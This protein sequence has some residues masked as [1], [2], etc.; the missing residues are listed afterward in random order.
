MAK[1]SKEIRKA[2]RA[3]EEA[4][5]ASAQARGA[6]RSHSIGIR[7]LDHIIEKGIY[8]I[9]L[10]SPLAF[11]E[12][13]YWPFDITR[14]TVLWILTIMVLTAYLCR[15]IAAREFAVSRPLAILT[16][17]ILL[18]LLV[19]TVSTAL[20]IFPGI[21]LFSGEGRN[22]GLVSL[23]SIFLLFL[24]LINILRERGQ[25]LRCLKLFMVSS[26]V[27]ALLGM[28]QFYG[29]I[30]ET[31]FYIVV[32]LISAGTAGALALLIL[33]GG[34]NSPHTRSCALLFT[35]LFGAT[36]LL[37]VDTFTHQHILYA[38]PEGSDAFVLTPKPGIN[39]DRGFQLFRGIMAER[40]S[41]TFGNPDF[42]IM[43]LVL[44]IPIAYAFVLRR[45]WLYAVPL[46]LI[47]FC[48]SMSKPV[49]L[50][51][52]RLDFLAGVLI[53]LLP[54]IGTL[55][56]RERRKVYAGYLGSILLIIVCLFASNV[57]D[58]RD[59]AVQKANQHL[60]GMDCGHCD[61][62][63]L[64]EIAL[65]TLDSPK[66]WIIG[67]GP[68]TF[69]DTF[70]QHVTLE[71]AQDRPERR[72]D[73]VH[74]SFFEALATTGVP[75]LITYLA[76]LLAPMAYIL[77]RLRRRWGISESAAA[78]A[79]GLGIVLL[80]IKAITG[81]GAP[82]WV[83]Y[84]F[85]VAALAGYLIH[86]VRE[87]WEKENELLLGMIL[88]S[89]LIYTAFTWAMFDEVIP[90]A[91]FWIVMG[92]GIGLAIGEEPRMHVFRWNASALVTACMIPVVLGLGI[93]TAYEAGRPLAANYYYYK[94]AKIENTVSPRDSLPYYRKAI[95][96]NPAEVRYLWSYAY[97]LLKSVQRAPIEE[98]Y[99]N[100]SECLKTINKAIGKEPESAMLYLNRAQFR[101]SC[102]PVFMKTGEPSGMDKVL[103]DVYKAIEMYPNGY[104]GYRLLAQIH[105]EQGDYKEAIAADEKVLVI[106][107]RDLETLLRI[108]VNEVLYGEELED[109]GKS[110]EAL[111]QYNRAIIHLETAVEVKP[112]DAT[113]E[114]YLAV[115]YRKAGFEEKAAE[116]FARI[117]PILQKM[118]EKQPDEPFLYFLLGG[119]YANTGEIEK[120]REAYQQA[121]KLAP[122]YQ[123][124]SEALERL[125]PAEGT[126]PA[127]NE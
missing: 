62:Q 51:D 109:A 22:L 32:G 44:A 114:Y 126:P 14:T 127:A 57:L 28:Y 42:L 27:V 31:H 17:F 98:Q 4:R 75:G 96:H 95:R 46:L 89:V 117:L 101:Y 65:K 5:E 67:S 106:I 105:S 3:R 12:Q 24:M 7:L 122:G 11:F 73:K 55:I 9:I 103:E 74:N 112:G 35:I 49:I 88:L 39:M 2:K 91:F 47:V 84:M 59:K 108:G 82:Y 120:A 78:A 43:F 111:D 100:C 90:H 34:R 29:N 41:S 18:Y 121:L 26:T 56:P 83:A 68:N 66:A 85:V 70:Q 38:K 13:T 16:I 77:W 118:V 50:G 76:V 23:I 61:R 8:A 125:G 123:A 87:H 81:A 97:A 102:D 115:A 6:V 48:F 21:S 107:P 58:V 37:L 69:R 53:L 110:D 94:A 64:R 25:L 124:A 19:Y 10:F 33:M 86:W 113:A 63:Q 92:I 40:A 71:Y 54:V 45:R 99:R 116:K 72:E 80:A 60:V 36:I 15:I 20:S 79:I 119:A 52:H 104:H 93:F 1:R 30:R